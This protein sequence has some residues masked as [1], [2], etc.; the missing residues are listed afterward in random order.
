MYVLHNVDAWNDVQIGDETFLAVYQTA[1]GDDDD[2]S[3]SLS[4][5]GGTDEVLCLIDMV[6]N[7]GLNDQ[8][9]LKEIEDLC[10]AINSVEKMLKVREALI[11]NL[12]DVSDF[13]DPE[14][15]SDDP[16]DYDDEDD[17]DD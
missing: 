6:G 16:A 11:S 14:D 17:Q 3:F 13:L 15:Y 2:P 12:P 1:G 10:P 7:Y 9:L 4:R 5:E 8:N